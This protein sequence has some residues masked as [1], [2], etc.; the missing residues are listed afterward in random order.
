VIVEALAVA[1]LPGL[2]AKAVWPGH[3]RDGVPIVL[4]ASLLGWALGY[5]VFHQ[6]LGLHELH[7]FRA[8]GV[9]AGAAGALVV[10]AALRAMRRARRRPRGRRLF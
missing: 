10:L 1:A 4:T 5:L 6:V 3:E 8:D 7:A 9:L 2:I